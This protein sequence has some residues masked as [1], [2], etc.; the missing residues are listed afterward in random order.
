MIATTPAY[1]AACAKKS[2]RPVHLVE[3]EGYGKVFSTQPDGPVPGAKCWIGTIGTLDQSIDDLNGSSTLQDVTLTV[4]DYRGLITA[5]FPLFTFEG[6]RLTLK[7]GFPG[8]AEAD[9][10]TLFTGIITEVASDIDNTAYTFTAQDYNRVNQQVV[11]LTGDD[12]QPTSN[13]HPKTVV[14]NPLDILIEI[15]ETQIGY[16]DHEID[17]A[18]I[19]AARDQLFAGMSFEFSIT[20]P[21]DAKS[22][23]EGELLKP[24][25][26]YGFTDNL[27]RYTVDFFQPLEGGVTAAMTLDQTNLMTMPAMAQADLVNVI[28][29][30]FDSD[31]DKF[32]SET[33]QQD[34][35]SIELYG[36]QGQQVIE[37]QGVRS[38]FQ[39]FSLAGMV[40]RGIF[41]RYGNKN[42][43]VE[44]TAYWKFA[45][46]M[47]GDFVALTHPLVPNRKTGT[48]GVTAQMFKVLER[49]LDPEAA[50]C[51]LTLID[52][53]AAAGFGTRR[54]APLAEAAY[55]AASAADKARYLFMSN[56]TGTQS[57]G[58]KNGLLG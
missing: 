47:V 29:Y 31:G 39:G 56:T 12:G 57:N 19:T 24:L 53:S 23:I 37:S 51:D 3:I 15:L 43:T 10:M 54:Y 40:A 50:T 34:A 44:V 35:A 42:P 18:T 7:A 49:Q 22:F 2:V 4:L 26:G 16:A 32:M 58:D 27:G 9:F 30:R 14:G 41:A 25:G 55:A 28:S 21:P 33:V 46:L 45:K 1:D 20:S 13:D 5:D 6:V 11:Y 17:L 36:A 38:G 8:L 48:M 52:A